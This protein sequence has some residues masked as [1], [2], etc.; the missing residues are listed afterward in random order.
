MQCYVKQD[1]QSW[2]FPQHGQKPSYCY[3]DPEYLQ[4]GELRAA[5][6][7]AL[8]QSYKDKVRSIL[9]FSFVKRWNKFM[10][11]LKIM[12]KLISSV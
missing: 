11:I 12:L 5:R 6:T 4:K 10:K 9:D 2:M 3:S 7:N 8:A 1:K